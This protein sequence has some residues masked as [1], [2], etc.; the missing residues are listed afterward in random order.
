MQSRAETAELKESLMSSLNPVVEEITA[1]IRERSRTSRR[2]YLER[3]QRTRDEDPPKQILSCGNLAHG[4][5]AC[6]KEDKETIRLMQSANLGII[7]SY[8]DVIAAHQPMGDYPNLIKSFA[9]ELGSTAQVAGGVPAMCDGVTQG[10]TGMELSLFSRD[11]IALATAVSLSHNIFDAAMCL[12]TCD[13]IVP[14]LMI[15][16]LQFGHI[17]VGFMPA[18]PMHSGIPNKEKANVRQRYAEGKATKEELLEAETASYHSAGTCTFYGTANSNQVMMEMIG[19]QLPGCSFINPDQP[20][21]TAMI[22]ETVFRLVAAADINSRQFT[23]LSKVVTEESVVNALV[24]LLATGGSTNHTLHLVAMAKAAGIDLRWEDFDALSREVPLICKVYPNGDE[25]VNAFQRA[26]GMAYLM[27]ELRGAGLVNENVTTLMGEGLEIHEY[28]P[29]LAE[30]GRVEWRKHVT[31]SRWSEVLRPVSEPFNKD[32]GLRLVRGNIGEGI[33][34]I[35]A[36]KPKQRKTTAPCIIFHEQSELKEAFEAGKLNRDFVAV[37]RF[38]GPKSNGMPELHHLTPYLGVLQ[39]R[40]YQVALLTDGRMSGASGKVP[41]AIHVTPEAMDGGPIS[42]LRDGDV[43]TIDADEGIISVDIEDSVL[44]EREPASY[45]RDN[46]TMGRNLFEAFRLQ[47]SE[48]SRG[49]GIF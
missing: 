15:G 14:G 16:S 47:V 41:A 1:R 6:S 12:G 24:G 5:A 49:A 3:M 19:V 42:R 20:L 13:K 32:G 34:K 26:G 33:I 11:V 7:N 39:D 30:N 36:V 2:S 18:G 9:R 29:E 28:E 17:P 22:R 8:N 38:Q 23:P 10:R 35:S 4:Y 45:S 40:G 31:E 44:N 25:D 37:V 43:V 46:G 48:P 21:R 27:Y